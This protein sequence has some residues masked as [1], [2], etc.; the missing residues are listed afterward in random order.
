[1]TDLMSPFAWCVTSIVVLS[2]I[3]LPIGLSMIG[4]SVLYLL[5]SG[6]DVGIAA[7][8]LLQGLQNTYT[9]LAI[10]L[11]ILA[12][13]LM[14]LGSL[15]DR[16]LAWCNALVGRFRGG[17]GHVNVVSSLIF[18]G[19]SGSAIADVV[20]V[21]KLTMDMM[22]KDGRYTPA[23]AAAITAATATIGPIIPPSIP[24]VLYALIS[25][26][27]VGYLF[28]AGVVPGLV[29]TVVMMALVAWQARRR[30]FPTEAPVPMRQFL[31]LTWTALPALM[32]PVVLLGGIYSGVMTPTE[33]AAVAALYALLVSVLLYRSV[34]LLGL[35]RALLGSGRQ[36]ATVGLLIA[37]ALVFNYVVTKED[38]PRT[39]QQFLAG[40]ELSKVGFLLLVNLLLLLLGALLEGGTILL[41]IVPIL[42]PTAQAL[43]VD[44]V[45][46]GL[47]VTVNLMIGL[48]TPPYGLLLF[49]VSS[50][51]RAPLTT[52]I[53]EVMPYVWVLIAALA[54]LT[55]VPDAVLWLPRLLGYKG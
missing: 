17:M 37:G 33:S 40:Y 29:M 44:M 27:S 10:P 4:G 46:F 32:M 34:S 1:M 50:L 38:V 14:N 3:G 45:H 22:T 53:R 25:D 9:L 36:M 26:T 8:Q 19:M 42:I 51:A 28:A 48:V 6:Q 5:L 54:F 31:P 20:G 49:I 47:V 23:W 30:N 21:G 39:V 11:F 18:S 2:L 55:F 15:S 13:E 52:V 43:G 12:A 24:L 16:L 35:Y 7:E 41:V